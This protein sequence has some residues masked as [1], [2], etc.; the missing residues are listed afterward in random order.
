MG[1]NMAPCSLTPLTR[2]GILGSITGEHTLLDYEKQGSCGSQML[3]KGGDTAAAWR[4][5]IVC[6]KWGTTQL[7]ATQ[8]L[9]TLQKWFAGLEVPLQTDWL[10]LTMMD[11]G[12]WTVTRTAR[13]SSVTLMTTWRRT[14]VGSC[15]S[16]V[17][18]G[19]PWLSLPLTGRTCWLAW[20]YLVWPLLVWPRALK[21]IPHQRTVPLSTHPPIRRLLGAEQAVLKAMLPGSKRPGVLVRA[22]Q[23][24]T[25]PGALV[26]RRDAELAVTQ[27]GLQ[28][29]TPPRISRAP[30]D[31]QK[32]VQKPNVL[33]CRAYIQITV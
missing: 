25:F 33:K 11:G 2:S 16:P 15:R 8:D 18:E 7:E 28:A 29:R 3:A 21:E 13:I 19:I 27:T 9:Q 31:L 23:A 24:T 17:Q 5:S 12:R 30:K 32:L 1:T 20:A 10:T 26:E 4:A 22:S 6:P 14:R